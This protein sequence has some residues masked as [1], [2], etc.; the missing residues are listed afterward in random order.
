[1]KYQIYLHIWLILE[2]QKCIQSDCICVN[3]VAL[4][5]HLE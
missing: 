4:V 1:M 2:T 3:I 5:T